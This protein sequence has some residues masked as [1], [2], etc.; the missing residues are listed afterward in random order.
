MKRVRERTPGIGEAFLEVLFTYAEKCEP[1]AEDEINA[2]N[3]TITE[4][5][6]REDVEKTILELVQKL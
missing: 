3:V 2:Y 6:T 1:A 4:E 5:M